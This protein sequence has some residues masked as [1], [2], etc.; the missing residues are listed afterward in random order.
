MTT[1]LILQSQKEETP[2]PLE[3]LIYDLG[4]PGR[5]GVR[6]P[7]SDV[8]TVDLPADLLRADLD[9]PEVSE[10][11]V[12][13][14]FVRLSHFNHS[15]D[16]GFYPLGSCTMKYNPKVN[17]D[18][19]RL[20]GFAQVHPLQD[21]STAQGALA[22]MYQLQEWL[23]EISGMDAVSLQPA[24]GAQ[25]EFAGILMIRAYHLAN[26]EGHRTK[27]IVPDSAHGT[28]PATTAMAGLEV[29]EI[30]S[31]ANGDVDLDK[32]REVCG[33]DMAGMMITVPNTLGVFETHI[34]DIVEIIHGC[35]GLMYMDGANMNAMLGV[36]KPAELGFDVMHY[37]L[38]KTFSTPHGGGG[39]GSGPVAVVEKLAPFLPGP[40]V[41]V[42][43]EG[44]GDEPPLYGLTMPEQSIGA[45]KAFYGNFGM[46]VRAF[47]YISTYGAEGLRAVTE[48]AV[49]NANYI[50]ARLKDAYPMPFDRVCGHEF[51]CEGH[52]EGVE[53]IHALDI[54][55][56]LMDYGIHPPTNYFPLIVPEA[57]LIEPTET[58]SK[59]SCDDFADAMLTIAAE[60]KEHPELLHD[61]PHTTP[62][63]R[64][65]DVLAAKQ[66]ILCC[67]PVPDYGA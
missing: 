29:I 12:M 46:M 55:K 5:Q 1:E 53:G 25:G 8:P 18:M 64:V 44:E 54:S 58:E 36:A 17:E 60:A 41:T 34:K 50:R 35:G 23:A 31:D 28:N 65:D 32:L 37:N 11:D 14:H 49:L 33:E 51:V 38:H 19:A 20:P 21:P 48:H 63:G 40:I 52:W 47:S 45:L 61:A 7:D 30:P 56:R 43:E 4:A 3:P 67:R 27:I 9:L 24:A 2:A 15:V 16:T 42:V 59:Q 66:L 22:M 10:Q 62:V 13:R 26:G 39:P 6:L 57:L